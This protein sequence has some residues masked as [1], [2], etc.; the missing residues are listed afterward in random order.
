MNDTNRDVQRTSQSKSFYTSFSIPNALPIGIHSTFS[1]QCFYHSFASSLINLSD[2]S[3]YIASTY[4]I[5]F[6]LASQPPGSTLNKLVCWRYGWQFAASAFALS[7]RQSKRGRQAFQKSKCTITLV[8][9]LPNRSKETKSCIHQEILR[10]IEWLHASAH[11]LTLS[12]SQ[13]FDHS[14]DASNLI[15]HVVRSALL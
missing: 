1:L 5:G 8:D 15:V 9:S 10:F 4:A 7:C 13:V 6:G 12:Y 2:I 11:P 14:V 3:F